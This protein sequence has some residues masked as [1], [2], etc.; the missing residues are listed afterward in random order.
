MSAR[1]SRQPLRRFATTS[2]GA[3]AFAVAALAPGEAE[4]SGY[5]TARYGADHGSPAQANTFA[6]Y[7]N[8]AALGG[9][10]GTT[11]TGDLSVLLRFARYNRPANALSP[12]ND[13]LL[14]DQA[15]LDA[16]TGTASLTNVLPL[17]FVGINTDFGTENLRAGY[18]FYIPF[19]GSADWTRREGIPGVPGTKDSVAR[20]HNISGQILAIHN[21]FALAYRFHPRF[22]VGASVSPVIHRVTTVRA[23]NSD[24]SDDTVVN[25]QL[26]EGRSLLEASGF[27]L[28]ATAGL[29]FEPVDGLHLGLAYLSQ[30]GFGETR[31]SGT[32]ETK[33]GTNP[34]TK[35]DV[36]LL[37]SYPDIV[38]L[39][40][41]WR[42]TDRLVLRADASYARWSVFKYQCV[43]NPG[44]KC[45]VADDGRD[46]SDGKVIL[47]IP[48]RWHDSVG[49]RVGPGFF[50]NEQTELFGSLSLGT[51]PVPD[52]TI[53]A[54]TLDATRIYATLGAKYDF[55]KHLSLAG[56]YNHIYFFD[57][58]TKGKS[59]VN[60]PAHPANQP[61]GGDY[62]VSRSPSANGR[63]RSQIGFV[64]V[65]VAYT[66]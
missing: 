3:A 65:N 19:G 7:F 24:G 49:V 34:V 55:S 40:V 25:G 35:Q 57:V 47:N 6:V 61:G 56:S 29:Y 53:D 11:L 50:L 23:R 51:S 42:A 1:V 13:D 4:A 33:L 14:Y 45:A 21:T 18:A 63:Y 31:L 36:D 44:E 28:A 10:K 8:P 16:N 37:Q 52:E 62:N 48:R 22:S 12:S 30:P 54:S 27:N 38:R 66:F 9:T 5:L 26:V 60:I 58:D 20:W 46:L 17:P 32:L 39:G 64:N 2:L 43:V 59:E 41:D 15:Y